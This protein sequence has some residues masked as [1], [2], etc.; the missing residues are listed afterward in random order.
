MQLVFYGD[1]L[2]YICILCPTSMVSH[3]QNYKLLRKT[4]TEDLS[5]WQ[6]L[7]VYFYFFFLET[8]F[9]KFEM[10]PKETGNIMN[11]MSD[12]CY[13]GNIKT[14]FNSFLLKKKK[15]WMCKG[16]GGDMSGLFLLCV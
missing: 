8:K 12:S 2:I 7:H 4:M 5:R 16:Q 6:S 1:K 14:C 13:L 11:E 3:L 10:S 9:E 15:K